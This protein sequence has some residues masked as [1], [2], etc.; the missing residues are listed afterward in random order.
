MKENK[1]Y[2]LV[3]TD[4]AQLDGLPET[5]REAAAMAYREQEEGKEKAEG[6]GKGWLFTLDFPSY[7][8]FMTYSTQRELRKQMYMAKNTVCT[9]ENGENNLEI[10]KRLVNLRREIAQLLGYKTYADYVLKRRM[11]S[12]TRNVYK[13]LDNLIDAYK[14]TAIEERAELKHFA[15]MRNGNDSSFKLAPWDIQFYAH[16]LQ[17][18]KYN[19]DAEMLRPYFQ[20]DKVIGGVFGLANKLYGIT[21]KENKDIPVYHPDVKAY[22]V[23]D[24]DGS[25]LAVFYADFH[26]RKGKQGGAWMTEYQGQWIERLDV[27]KPFGPDKRETSGHTSAW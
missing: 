23:F 16:K 11:A 3:I 17:M 4:E 21:F 1:A 18:K 6:N 15:Q 14:P 10:C 24:K 2:S 19:L 7:S 13:L 20:L 9:H 8:P 27:K 25:Y 26:P 12:N 5:A 22:E